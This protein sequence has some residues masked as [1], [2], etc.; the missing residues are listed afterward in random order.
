MYQWAIPECRSNCA[1]E[2][3]SLH[4]TFIYSASSLIYVCHVYC[5]TRLFSLRALKVQHIHIYTRSRYT[6]DYSFLILFLI[7]YIY[8]YIYLSLWYLSCYVGAFEPF[9]V[10]IHPDTFQHLTTLLTL[11]LRL[12]ALAQTTL[13]STAAGSESIQA[14]RSLFLR[15]LQIC[16]IGTE[17]LVKHNQISLINNP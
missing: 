9:C 12:L 11:S 2:Y 16:G 15:V 4:P 7:L 8:I 5:R 3:A 10:D 6:L 13:S 14:A 17:V 1:P